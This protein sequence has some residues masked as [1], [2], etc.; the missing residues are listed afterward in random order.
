LLLLLCEVTNEENISV[1]LSLIPYRCVP[2]PLIC[3]VGNWKYSH[4]LLGA[5][6]CPV[7]YETCHWCV[8]SSVTLPRRYWHQQCRRFSKSCSYYS[9]FFVWCLSTSTRC[10]NWNYYS[11]TMKLT[12]LWNVR[13]CILVYIYQYFGGNSYRLLPKLKEIFLCQCV[14]FQTQFTLTKST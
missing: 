13:T 3:P 4:I 1:F 5:G 6:Y 14:Y 12:A 8:Y 11:I 9:N 2:H 7:T 10:E